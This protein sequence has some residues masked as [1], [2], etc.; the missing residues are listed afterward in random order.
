M[1]HAPKVLDRDVIDEGHVTKLRQPPR[2]CQNSYAPN[3]T[4][5]APIRAARS[6][7]A[8]VTSPN[9]AA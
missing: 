2:N 3:R 1:R 6:S 9:T 4:F 5:D 8:V 7:T